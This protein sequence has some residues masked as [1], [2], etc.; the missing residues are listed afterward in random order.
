MFVHLIIIR[1]YLRLN[2]KNEAKKQ[3]KFIRFD[4]ISFRDIVGNNLH[5]KTSSAARSDWLEDENDQLAALLLYRD[6]LKKNLTTA[7]KAGGGLPR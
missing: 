6:T 3:E 5:F 1:H 2:G 4:S 7:A